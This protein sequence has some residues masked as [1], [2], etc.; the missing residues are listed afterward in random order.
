MALFDDDQRKVLL[1]VGIGM[2]ALAVLRG[3]TPAFRGAGRPLAKATIKGGLVLFEKGREKAAQFGEVFE[4][5][6][7]E[8]RAELEQEART[9]GGQPEE[10]SAGGNGNKQ[11]VQ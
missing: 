8:A 6:V 9:A 1:G 2:A 11:P 3:V 5:L 4:D 7:A 10:G